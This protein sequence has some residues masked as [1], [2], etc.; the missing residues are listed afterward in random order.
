MG[1]NAKMTRDEYIAH[2][3][4]NA[5]GGNGCD[6]NC[7]FINHVATR[8][9]YA[10]NLT[11]IDW[12][13][14]DGRGAYGVRYILD[15]SALIVRG[16]LGEAVFDRGGSNPALEW[17]GNMRGLNYI[18]GK[19]RCARDEWNYDQRI[20]ETDFAEWRAENKPDPEIISEIKSISAEHGRDCA[21]AL[22]AS[23]LLQ[24]RYDVEVIG[25][26]SD[27]GLVLSAQFILW[28]EGLKMALEQLEGG[29]K[30]DA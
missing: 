29:G 15:G 13:N 27:F 4:K 28:I 9:D 7:S 26:I 10:P 12:R 25:F 23:D 5:H 18:H 11:V 30:D 22:F 16:D 6:E 1:G 20:W 8:H 14:R 17:L 2:W 24:D 3:R 19:L 21:H